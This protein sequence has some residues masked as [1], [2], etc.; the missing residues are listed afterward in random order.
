MLR[1]KHPATDDPRPPYLQM[2]AQRTCNLGDDL[3]RCVAQQ[4]T[5]QLRDLLPG[6]RGHAACGELRHVD[7][8]RALVREEFLL[9]F[10]LYEHGPMC[11]HVHKH[12]RAHTQTHAPSL[13]GGAISTGELT[14]R[15]KSITLNTWAN[16]RA[17]FKSTNC[18]DVRTRNTQHPVQPCAS[19]ITPTMRAY[20]R[21]QN[22]AAGDARPVRV[23]ARRQHGR[24]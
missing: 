17:N 7:S 15:R 1:E 13:A 18:C 23:G 2:L 12:V 8:V 19:C 4:Q 20:T 6:D 21:R 22:I 16:S 3:I 14:K 10:H 9:V 24:L 5:L 11:T